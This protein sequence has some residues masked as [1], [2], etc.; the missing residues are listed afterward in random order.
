MSEGNAMT[1]KYHGN[2]SDLNLIQIVS[3]PTP[4]APESTTTT[5]TSIL[6]QPSSPSSGGGGGY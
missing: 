2:E 3:T 4:S 6:T 5:Q 1:G